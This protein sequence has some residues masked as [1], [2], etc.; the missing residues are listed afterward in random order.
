MSTDDKNYFYERLCSSY[1]SKESNGDTKTDL[2]G[3]TFTYALMSLSNLKQDNLIV[4]NN[5]FVFPYLLIPL[6]S[7][8]FD[9]FKALTL[10][11][12][13]S[14]PN[15]YLVNIIIS[16]YPLTIIKLDN[17]MKLINNLERL[18]S[19][20]ADTDLDKI[21]TALQM[22]KTDVSSIGAFII[23]LQSNIKDISQQIEENYDFENEKIND[24][25]IGNAMN[26]LSPYITTNFDYKL[27][28]KI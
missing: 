6:T 4:N 19:Y 21:A 11:N 26:D 24:I 25:T 12:A 28:P 1:N 18:D 2:L 27:E 23:G 22:Q 16:N 5:A 14:I 20:Y 17:Q 13:Q 8:P 7:I 10:N 15:T 9:G 3:A